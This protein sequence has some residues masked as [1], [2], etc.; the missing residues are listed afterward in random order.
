MK[1]RELLLLRHGKSDWQMATDDF[2]R[3][4]KDRGKRGAQRMGVWLQEQQLIP[5][6][7]LSS[8][9]LRALVTA[10]KTCKAL[11]MGVKHIHQEP[12]L[13]ATGLDDLCQ[14][15]AECPSNTHRILLVGH[16]P[17]LEELLTFL[18]GADIPL[19]KDGKLLPTATL[20]RLKMPKDWTQL[21]SGCATLLLIQRAVDLPKGFPFPNHDSTEHRERPAYYYH[22]SSVI[23][24]RLLAGELQ[25]LVIL[26][27]QKKHWVVPKGI[28]DPG[29]SAQASAAKEAWEEAGVEGE[30]A[31]QALGSYRYQKWGAT[32]T[33]DVYPMRVKRLIPEEEWHENHRG[34]QW[35]S[36]DEAK[37]KLKQKALIPLLDTLVKQITSNQFR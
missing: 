7:I 12:R 9:A 15:L 20:A 28:Q 27:S 25:I 34:R 11:G 3:P 6:Y 37:Q 2:N 22:Q 36:P 29:K 21:T 24:Y 19:P 32:C 5:D 17:V 16:N 4:L 26:S 30:V 23:P 10:E 31:E 18:A 1:T 14:V 33:V 8:P 35:V 13:Y